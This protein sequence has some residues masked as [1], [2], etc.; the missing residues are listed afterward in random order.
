MQSQLE[1]DD[2]L[3]DS[4]NSRKVFRYIH[5][6]L[7]SRSGIQI[8]LT[9]EALIRLYH[10]AAPYSPLYFGVTGTAIRATQWL[11]NKNDNPKRILFYSPIA[12]V[13]YITI[14]RHIFSITQ[15]SLRMKEL[16]QKFYGSRSNISPNM[17][18]TDYSAAMRQSV[19]QE[20]I[21]STLQSYFQKTY[22]LIQGGNE[23]NS[24]NTF[25]HIYSLNY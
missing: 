5:Y 13:D 16:E 10:L 7:I 4:K 6:P 21:A 14:E 12:L 9:D 17:I 8:T 23:D 22:D 19:I 11:K 20:M 25:V 18:E 1:E 2:R 15:P 24:T 3:N